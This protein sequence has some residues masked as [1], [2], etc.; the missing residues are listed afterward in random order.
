VAPIDVVSV[1]TREGLLPFH[2][3]LLEVLATD[4]GESAGPE[5]AAFLDLTD[6]IANVRSRRNAEIG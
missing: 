2:D 6:T 4:S 3:V 1:E 5:L